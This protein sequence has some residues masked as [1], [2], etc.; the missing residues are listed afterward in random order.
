MEKKQYIR[1]RMNMR[2]TVDAETLLSGSVPLNNEQGESGYQGA[3][4]NN[5][6]GNVF[7][8]DQEDN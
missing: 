8:D 6:Y 3:G 4:Q 7:D 2:S 1:P 5:I